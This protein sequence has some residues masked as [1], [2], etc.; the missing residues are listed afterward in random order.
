MAQ[1][2]VDI[3]DLLTVETGEL[4]DDC[5]YRSKLSVSQ[6]NLKINKLA[7]ID[8]LLTSLCFAHIAAQLLCSGLDE[9]GG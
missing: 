4:G 9:G 1:T 5:L 7:T 6:D 3:D 8:G 2:D